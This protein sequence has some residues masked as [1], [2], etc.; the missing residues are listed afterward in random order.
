MPIVPS[1]NGTLIHRAVGTKQYTK[2]MAVDF[3]FTVE[4]IQNC[5]KGIE[6]DKFEMYNDEAGYQVVVTAQ[7]ESY[8]KLQVNLFRFKNEQLRS[9]VSITTERPITTANSTGAI[10]CPTLAKDCQL[11]KLHSLRRV[12]RRQRKPKVSQMT[13]IEPNGRKTMLV[14]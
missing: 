6:C 10:V 9:G 5:K 14:I 8:G 7:T 2:N 3:A 12:T 13:F 1:H 11:R 4:T